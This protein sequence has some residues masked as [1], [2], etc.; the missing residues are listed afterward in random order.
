LEALSAVANPETP[1]YIGNKD[2]LLDKAI[3]KNLLTPQYSE[4]PKILAE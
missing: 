3:V 1:I 2:K 4:L